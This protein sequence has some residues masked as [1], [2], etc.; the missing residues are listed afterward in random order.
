M[1]RSGVPDRESSSAD[2]GG[3]GMVRPAGDGAGAGR[4]RPRKPAAAGRQ[5]SYDGPAQYRG[6]GPLASH[7]M[8]AICGRPGCSGTAHPRLMSDDR[9]RCG[10]GRGRTGPGRLPRSLAWLE[11]RPM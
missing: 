9:E 2:G 6:R 11:L 1:I 3:R 5:A 7:G 4:G 10:G 8:L